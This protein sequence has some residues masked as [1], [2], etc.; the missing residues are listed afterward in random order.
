MQQGW[1]ERHLQYADVNQYSIAA[2]ITFW[3]GIF[4]IAMM[5]FARHRWGRIMALSILA[6]SIFIVAV[7]AIYKIDRGRQGMAIV[8]NQKVQARLATADNAGNVLDLPPGS[9]IKI[10]S[11]RGDW[12]Y[13][14]LPNNLRGWIPATD[15]ERIRL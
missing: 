4:C 15:A 11:K 9:E 14:A 12:I 13:A 8:T 6:W 5:I 1:L 7:F 3:V 2:A 10:L